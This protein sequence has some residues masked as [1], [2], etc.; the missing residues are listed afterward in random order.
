MKNKREI[1]ISQTLG[2]FKFHVV[3]LK[4]A[5]RF[6]NVSGRRMVQQEHLG[7]ENEYSPPPQPGRTHVTISNIIVNG[8]GRAIQ[9]SRQ[10]SDVI[11][12]I[13]P[14]V[15][16]GK[17]KQECK[18]TRSTKP[19]RRFAVSQTKKARDKSRNT[20]DDPICVTA[21]RPRTAASTS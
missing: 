18:V 3:R 20:D 7:S 4:R 6:R 12:M 14:I 11:L 21:N 8:G 16:T 17:E 15:M 2:N 1:I 9:G 5:F 19:D 10:K 13:E